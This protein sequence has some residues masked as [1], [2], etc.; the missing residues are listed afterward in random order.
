MCAAW[1]DV[2]VICCVLQ[3]L[4]HPELIFVILYLQRSKHHTKPIN[5]LV[6]FPTVYLSY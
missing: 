1:F 3:I 6:R 4:K 2:D 5:E